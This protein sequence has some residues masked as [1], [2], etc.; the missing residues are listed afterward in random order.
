MWWLILLAL[1]NGVGTQQLYVGS[2][3]QVGVERCM[4]VY[5]QPRSPTCMPEV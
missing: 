4:A 2:Y 5:L 1:Y 3:N